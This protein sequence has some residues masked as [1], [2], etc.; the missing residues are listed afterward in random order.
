MLIEDASKRADGLIIV[1]AGNGNYSNSFNE[2][3]GKLD[4]PVVRTSR[5]GNGLIVPDSK[6]DIYPNIILSDNLS[7]TKARILLQ[8]A[9]TITKDRDKI[10]EFFSIF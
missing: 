9:L 10:Q 3:I 8:L 2:M 6:F 7:P 1:G 4:I 5:I